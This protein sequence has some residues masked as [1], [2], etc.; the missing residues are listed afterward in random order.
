MINSVASGSSLFDS[1]EF[2]KAQRQSWNNAAAGWQEWWNI[3]ENGATTVS[4]KLVELA[5][6]E[7]DHIILDLAT[8]TGEPAITAAKKLMGSQGHVLATDI[9]PRMLAIAKQRA[10]ALGLQDKVEFRE[11]DA[12]L[13]E[14]SRSSF[15]AVLCRWGLMYF[16]H[17]ETTL[18]L[19]FGGLMS[20]GR[21][22]CAVWAYPSKVPLISFSMGVVMRELN[23]PALPPGLPVP[24]ALADI[25]I[26]ENALTK[27]GFKNV[28]IE[29]LPVIFR[30]DSVQDFISYT[31]ATAAPIKFILD[32]ESETRQE[33][34]WNKISN[35]VLNNYA[36]QG[37]NA[38]TMNNECIC[39][40]GTKKE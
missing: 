5:E 9:S 29:Q 18:A 24:F 14:L 25:G 17:L 12:E 20:S 26:L 30:F 13:L 40:V 15:N 34:I 37:N 19:I 11:S 1:E 35:E 22:A 4:N 28:Q 2:K 3:F 33:E 6:I 39:V 23:I 32:K 27:A 7:A 8:G 21:F 10:A 16:P 31:K 38:V 36:N